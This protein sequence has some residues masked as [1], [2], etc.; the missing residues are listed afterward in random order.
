[1]MKRAMAVLGIVFLC[2]PVVQAEDP[3]YFVDA[4][5]KARVEARLGKTD[6]TPTDMLG[7]TSLTAQGRGITDLT[8]LEYATNLTNLDLLMNEISDLSPLAG[9][10]NL[11]FLDLATIRSATSLRWAD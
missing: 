2:S 10:T 11:T 7:L 3:V 6:P 4:N 5:L 1:M 8:G 9:L